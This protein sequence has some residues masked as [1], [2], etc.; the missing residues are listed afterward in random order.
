MYGAGIHVGYSWLNG[1]VGAHVY[2]WNIEATVGW[3]PTKMPLT[4]E[5]IS[6]IGW[7]ITAYSAKWN[8]NALYV[9]FGQATKGYRYEHSTNGYLTASDIE[10]M[11]II[12]G[13]C[14]FCWG[15]LGLKAG[16]GYGWCD[17]ADTVTGELV[18][19]YTFEL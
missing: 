17:Q 14:R 15:P 18:A 13:G 9:S 6:S 3:M 19:S 5:H 2:V 12:M 8:K 4:D 1:V 10:S 16:I 11:W 7:G